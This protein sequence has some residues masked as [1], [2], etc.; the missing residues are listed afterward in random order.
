MV[1]TLKHS[2]SRIF[3][4]VQTH[5]ATFYK[6][7]RWHKLRTPKTV[8]KFVKEKIREAIKWSE[9]SWPGL[10]I[11]NDLTICLIYLVSKA[12]PKMWS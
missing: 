5:P 9:K 3:C 4:S 12:K 1:Y 8:G 2:H 10:V 6:S 11:T 7:S